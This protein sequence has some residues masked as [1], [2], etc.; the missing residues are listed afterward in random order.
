MLKVDEISS[1][2]IHNPAP[3]DSGAAATNTVIDSH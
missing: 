2:N 3:C 1:A